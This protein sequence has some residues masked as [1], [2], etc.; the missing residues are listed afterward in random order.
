M[1]SKLLLAAVAATLVTAPGAALAQRAPAATIVVVDTARVYRDCNACR[2]AATN[3]QGQLTSAQQRAQ[4]LGQQLQTEQASLQ[5]A[6]AALKG[7]DPDAALKGRI[8]AFQQRQQNA[9]QELARL[10]TNIQSTQ[11]NVTRQIDA[12]IGPIYQQVMTTRGAN[13]A[14]DVGATLASAAGL[15]VTNDVLA[16]LNSQLPSVSVTPLPQQAQPQGR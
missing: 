12:K 11:A 8:T 4:T 6:V 10:Q 14:V 9:Q 1:N 15:D 7:K 2:T 13:M 16:A 5:T 3:L